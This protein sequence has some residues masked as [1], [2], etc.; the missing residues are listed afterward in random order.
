MFSDNQFYSFKH[1]FKYIKDLLIQATIKL[2][3]HLLAGDTKLYFFKSRQPSVTPTPS[4]PMLMYTASHY[5]NNSH[6]HSPTNTH[7]NS[8]TSD[9]KTPAFW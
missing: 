1:N 2:Q 5:E 3:F 9:I 8:S 6:L 7:Y 4:C